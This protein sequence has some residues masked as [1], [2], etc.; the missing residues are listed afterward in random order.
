MTILAI[1]RTLLEKV[2][3]DAE[4]GPKLEK[5]DTIQDC[6]DVIEAYCQKERLKQ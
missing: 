6:A 2:F 1:R 4:F 3:N 5:A